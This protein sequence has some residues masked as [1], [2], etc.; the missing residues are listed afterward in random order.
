MAVT[1]VMFW[2]A[3]CCFSHHLV[4]GSL[5]FVLLDVPS[6]VGPTVCM[7]LIHVASLLTVTMVVHFEYLEGWCKFIVLGTFGMCLHSNPSL[8]KERY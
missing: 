5:A 4:L 3:E 6:S 1:T 7:L 2:W 8:S